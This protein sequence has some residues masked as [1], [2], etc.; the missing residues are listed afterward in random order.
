MPYLSMTQTA[1]LQMDPAT[2]S[3]MDSKYTKTE[4]HHFSRADTEM[5]KAI[6]PNGASCLEF[7]ERGICIR[8]FPWPG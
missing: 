1:A 8:S 5:V 4:A 6:L 3:V 2:H 7:E